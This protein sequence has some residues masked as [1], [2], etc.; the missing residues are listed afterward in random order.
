MTPPSK[1][2]KWLDK[3]T[4]TKRWPDTEEINK[5]SNFSFSTCEH[6]VKAARLIASSR[7][8]TRSI[9]GS[10]GTIY[11]QL[12]T[13]FVT[14]LKIRMDTSIIICN[15][16]PSLP[17]TRR[18]ILRRKLCPKRTA[19]FIMWSNENHVLRDIRDLSP[20]LRIIWA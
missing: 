10:Q 4:L 19:R 9:L 2:K 14:Q 7:R 18:S 8:I 1:T 20:Y 6:L 15:L 13:P 5:Q 12:R 11:M 3:S 17:A 16:R